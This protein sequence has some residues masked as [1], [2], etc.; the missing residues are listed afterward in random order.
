MLP[1]PSSSG[2]FNPEF[3]NRV[4]DIV[5]F[6]PLDQARSGHV[7]ELL[8]VELGRRLAE[9]GMAARGRQ[10][11]ADEL[12]VERGY[13]PAYGARPMRRLIQSEIED[14]LSGEILAGPCSA[15]L[16]G[17][18]RGQGGDSASGQARPQRQPEPP[19]PADQAEPGPAPARE[20]RL[21]R[22]PGPR[23]CSSRRSLSRASSSLT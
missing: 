13:D 14:P 4:D 21:D 22:P 6:Q 23:R 16:D 9:R 15:R 19:V 11:A 20:R 17:R 18:R 10:E 1:S 3:V 2:R 5:V 8:L 7:L 12:L